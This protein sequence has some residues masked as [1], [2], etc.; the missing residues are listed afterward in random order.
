[1]NGTITVFFS[2]ILLLILSLIFTII[3]GARVSTAKVWAERS[4]TTAMDSVLAEY[5]GPLWE[6]YHIFG[7]H[8]GSGSMQEKEEAIAAKLMDYMSYTLEP[9]RDINSLLYSKGIELYNSSVDSLATDQFAMLMDYE[10]TLFLNE[11]VEYMKYREIGK[12]IEFFLEKMSLMDTPKKVSIVY[13]QK[14]KAEEE[15][16]DIDEGILELM[17]SLDGVMTSKKG[18]ETTK[19]GRLKTSGS[20][21]KKLC[22]GEPT[23]D[24]VGINHNSIYLALQNSYID[25]KA[26]FQSIYSDFDQLEAVI[27]RQNEVSLELED[28]EAK[29]SE[30]ESMAEESSEEEEDTSKE[31][32]EDNE[33]VLEDIRKRIESLEKE[34]SELEK[35]KKSLINGLHSAKNELLTVTAGLEPYINEAISTID[36]ILPK[37]AAAEPILE[38]YEAT[39]YEQEDAIEED[40]FSGLVE[41]LWELKRYTDPKGFNFDSMKGIL[42]NNIK[43]LNNGR[44]YLNQVESA[45]NHEAFSTAKGAFQ[46]AES[47]LQSYQIE[48]LTL[49]YSSLVLD[50]SKRSDILDEIGT[51]IQGGLTS[52][53]VDPNQISRAELSQD[54]LP[55]SLAA[56]FGED[57]DFLSKLTSFFENAAIGNKNTGAADLFGTFGKEPDFASVLGDGINK[58][59]EHILYQ[60]YIRDHFYAYPKEGEDIKLRKPSVL[61]YEQEY[62][63][64]GKYNDFDNLSSVIS[65]IIFLRT[66]LDFVSLL[67][68]S[69]KCNEAK[70]AAA[71]LVGFTGLPILVSI[72][73]TI[74]MLIWAFSEALVDTCALMMDREVPVLKKTLLVQLPEIFMLNRSFFQS[75]AVQIAQ[76]KEIS[77]S[78]HEY[79]C[80]F[81]F[82]KKKKDLIYRAMDLIQENI[83]IRYD[84]PFYMQNVLF[85]YH[86]TSTVIVKPKFIAIPFILGSYNRRIQ[87]FQYTTQATYSY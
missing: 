54:Q 62:L 85:G 31:G 44:N 48:G 15:L 14:Q 59:A 22:Y 18:L 42:S 68:D 79:L 13:E 9:N 71:A 33:S 57:T 2:L 5:Y 63:L 37:L 23:Q 50:K 38:Q 17:E 20:F 43:V 55:S 84:E 77:I 41:N 28:E 24:K 32:K 81:L 30:A 58:I 34:L 40:I 65:R 8:T 27:E 56:L 6:E 29:L 4:L 36:M 26:K 53:V 60:E 39:L 3:E 21:V 66:I 83:Q 11:A 87:R 64:V 12:G 73:Q 75:K 35:T 67:G 78:Y 61:T 82:M 49:D 45:L 74:L 72:T 25:L 80:A 52:L 70:L 10:G 19:D 7:Y 16:V 46:A 86:A 69:S 1:M 47:Y 76:T 51:M